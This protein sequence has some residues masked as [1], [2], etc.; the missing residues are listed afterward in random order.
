MTSPPAE[1][2]MV[3]INATG[4]AVAAKMNPPMG[5]CRTGVPSRRASARWLGADSRRPDHNVRSFHD[6]APEVSKNVPM[7][8][9]SVSE[10]GNS[11]FPVPPR[12]VARK[13]WRR[14]MEKTRLPR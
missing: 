3:Q 4:N 14:A 10:E 7:L 5:A 9:G 8:I 13:P 6:T 1:D 11:M 2:G 12:R